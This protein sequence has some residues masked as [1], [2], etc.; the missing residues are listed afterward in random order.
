MYNRRVTIFVVFSILLLLVC[1]VRLGQMQ[2]LGAS[3]V[4][5]EIDELKRRMGR[6]K[7]ISTVRG[8]I[9]DRK[10][11][12]LATEKARFHVYINYTLSSY[13]DD[14][15]KRIMLDKAAKQSD[16]QAALTKVKDKIHDRDEQLQRIINVCAQ[17]EGA[18]PAIVTNRIQKIND[19][20]WDG[21]MFQAWRYNFSNSEVFG[22]YDHQVESIPF[23]VA[24]ADFEAKE[25][26][27]EKRFELATKIDIAEMHIDW[28]LL[29][30]KTDD[31]IF[32]AQLE[33]M[34]TDGIQ[35]LPNEDRFYPYGSA[36]AQTI[37]WVG[38]ASQERDKALFKDDRL[39]RYLDGELCGREDGVEYVCEA[40]LRGRRGQVSSD[41]DG[42]LMDQK[43]IEEGCDVQLTLDVE[44]QQAI[45]DYLASYDHDPNCGPGMSAVVIEVATSEILA[46]VSL[47]NYDLNRVR[48]DYD[49]LA[50]DKTNKPLINRA[51]NERYPPGSVVKPV[52]L[53]AGLESGQITPDDVISC[54]PQAAPTNWPNCWIYRR[55]RGVG[56]D[57][58]WTNNARNA[59]RGS[60]NIYFSHLAD[61]IEPG[62]L[63]QW[64]FKFGYGRDALFLPDWLIDAAKTDV[65]RHFDQLG[66][67]IW[68]GYPRARVHAFEDVPALRESDRRWFG[69]G[70][71]DFRVTP[72]QVANAMAAL[73]RE[74]VFK[75]PR[76]FKEISNLKSQISNSEG[77]DLGISL[78]TLAVIYDGM[79]AVV[80]EYGGTANNQFEP[81]LWL[82]KQQDVKIFGK[83]GSTERPEHAWFGGFAQDGSGRKIALAV[84]VEGGQHGSSDAAPLARDIIQLCI[85]YGYL[86]KSLFADPSS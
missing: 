47:P 46:L 15:I 35:I 64:L 66:G 36:A 43:P 10:G 32:A 38:S 77:V 84:I 27:H 34:D 39:L 6:T 21:R 40:I 86:G 5:Q 80:N 13:L 61:R 41:I 31:D 29:E 85:D 25:P 18:D 26:D 33:F 9:L 51:I 83:T 54:P 60:C 82:F 59:I 1:L 79:S 70:Q 2:L 20:V 73:A 11:N 7:Q 44:L 76:L 78:A 42:Q 63:Q 65:V 68:S 75:R 23:S 16:P 8:D 52:I 48:Y 69:I 45:E 58:Q 49:D 53:I 71:G 28:P 30:L 12:V 3:A 56:H 57:S 74:G 19:L 14:R 24:M 22:Q 62:V 37:G 50:K 72:L 4:Q 17:L 67:V 55:Y 81:S